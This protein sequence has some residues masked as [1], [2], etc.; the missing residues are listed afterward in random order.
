M[1]GYSLVFNKKKN[2]FIG[3]LDNAFF[4]GVD[5][6]PSPVT[7]SLP[8]IIFAIYQGMSA[9]ITP[10]FIFGSIVERDRVVPSIV[11]IFIWTTVVY[12]PIAYWTCNPNGWIYQLGSLDFAGGIPAHTSSGIA[13]LVYS[14]IIGR[15]HGYEKNKEIEPQNIINATFGTFLIWFGWFGFNGGSA[16][17]ANSRA[18]IACTVTNLAAVSGGLTW[19]FFDYRTKKKLSILGFCSGTITGLVAIT[20]G[21]GYVS[22]PSS[23]IFGFIAAASCRF[24]VKLKYFFDYDDTL[25]VFAIHGIGGFI[26]NLMTGIFAQKSIAALDNINI[27]GGLLDGNWMQI[28]YQ[29]TASVVGIVYSLLITAAILLIMN[30]TPGLSLRSKK[31]DEEEG[32]DKSELGES[33][34]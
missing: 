17:G 29:F 25:D 27:S 22:I 15:R 34:Y 18:A 30:I 12:D 11:F 10:A 4:I 6:H 13:A 8:S 21:S 2:P 28:I 1:I 32:I 7:D 9:A 3:G 5:D 14:I 20:P 16:L 19:M 26:G 24:A 23:V 33:V 31:E